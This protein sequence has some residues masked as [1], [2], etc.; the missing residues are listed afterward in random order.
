MSKQNSNR[1]NFKELI[2][3]KIH[4]QGGWVNAHVHADRAFTISIDK[5]KVYQQY[6]LEEKWDIVDEIKRNTSIDEYYSRIANAIELMIEQGVTAVGAFI[7]IDPICK[8]KAIKG[9]LKAREKYRN[10]ITIKYINQTLKGVIDPEARRWFEIGAEYVDIIGGLPRRD[11][12]DYGKGE[13]HLDI[14]LQTAKRLKKMVH[15]HVDQFNTQTD[16]ETELLC[17]KT[18]EYDLQGRVVAIHSISLA[19]H[20]KDYRERIYQKMVRAQLMVI[21]CPTA[22]IDS[23]RSEQL[24][25]RHNSLTPIDELIPRQITVAIGTDN[26]ADY[27]VPLC[28][29]DM[30]SELKLIAAGCRFTDYTKL[31]EMATING[32]KVLGIKHG[33]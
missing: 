1:W 4:K 22:W 27:M 21:A 19:A 28:D 7:D 16:R 14:L 25:P 31:V 5:L 13:E 9:A 8:D 10:D 2:L 23:P 18:I 24:Q 3:E 29:G 11:E 15:V 33:G 6:S 20:P 17:N 30:W 32:L 26:I 12:L